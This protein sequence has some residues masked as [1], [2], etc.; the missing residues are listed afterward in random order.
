MA[1]LEVLAVGVGG[2][3]IAGSVISKGKSLRSRAAALIT[4]AAMVFGVVAYELSAP[5]HAN[6]PSAPQADIVQPAG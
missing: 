1:I 5:S 3:L 4:G 2:G 6:P